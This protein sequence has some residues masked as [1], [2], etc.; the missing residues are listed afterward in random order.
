MD[1]VR[2]KDKNYGNRNIIHNKLVRKV[3]NKTTALQT[4][5]LNNRLNM[6][7]KNKFI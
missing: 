4:F 6:I 1:V 3:L 5:Y 7:K 2:Y